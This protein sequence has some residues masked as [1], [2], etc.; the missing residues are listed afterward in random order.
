[1]LENCIDIELLFRGATACSFRNYVFATMIGIFPGT[2]AFV[3]IGAA[4]AVAATGGMSNG[5]TS[6]LQSNC[7]NSGAD[8][9]TIVVLVVG[10]IATFIAVVIIGK[11]SRQKF[12]K[13][14]EEEKA[15]GDE[16]T[17]DKRDGSQ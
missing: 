17:G 11:Y 6:L 14:V 2:I 3:F 1:M 5:S 15:E 13:F 4:V 8:V 16:E 12:Q 7:M 9:V 10:I